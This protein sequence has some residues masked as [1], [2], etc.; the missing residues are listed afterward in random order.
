MWVNL[1]MKNGKITLINL[2]QMDGSHYV[3][4]LQSGEVVR[5]PYNQV[6]NMEVDSLAD[7]GYG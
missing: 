1:I 5:I 7:E 4:V 6:D 3:G 2:T